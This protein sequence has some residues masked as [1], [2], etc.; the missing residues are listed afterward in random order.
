MSPAARKRDV[1]VPWSQIGCE[2]NRERCFLNA[3][4]KLKKMRMACAD[5]DP[6][7]F[8]WSFR[9]KCSNAFDRKE[10]CAKFNRFE[11]FA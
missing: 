7:N 9:W 11:F 10:K 2:S 8:H 3:F 5:P 4:V 1:R 6:D